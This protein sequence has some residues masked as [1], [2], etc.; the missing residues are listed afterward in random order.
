MNRY[1][2]TAVL[3]IFLFS[4]TVFTYSLSI[5]PTF[6]RV[7]F[8]D[9]GQGDSILIESSNGNQLLIDSGRGARVITELASILKYGDKKIDAILATHYDADHIGGFEKIIDGYAVDTLIVNG[10]ETETKTAGDLIKKAKE[11]GI[12]IETVSRGNI[13]DL[14]EDTFVEILHPFNGKAVPKGNDGSIVAKVTTP[15]G[16]FILTGDAPQKV[17]KQLVA[18]D[19][20]KLSSDILK[21]GH[22]GSKSSSSESF[23]KTVNPQAV[24]ISA[25]ENNQYGHPNKEVLDILSK[26]KIPYLATYI[27]G[28]IEF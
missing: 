7:V 19:R 3:S 21:L 15:Y 10:A 18:L 2:P 13:I 23:L 27:E 28:S 12:L 4:I 8:L 9:V 11:N 20:E 22:H 14:G 24:V 16:T 6:G 26:L 1:L 25:G 17:E 5:S